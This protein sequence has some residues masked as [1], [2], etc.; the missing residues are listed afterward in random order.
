MQVTTLEKNVQKSKEKRKS[1]Y[2]EAAGTEGKDKL[3][4]LAGCREECRAL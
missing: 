4:A 2:F 3:E 1:H